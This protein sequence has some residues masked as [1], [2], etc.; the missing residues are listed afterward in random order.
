MG[1]ACP[2]IPGCSRGLWWVRGTTALCLVLILEAGLPVPTLVDG[3]DD[4]AVSPG[5]DSQSLSHTSPW[6]GL[7]IPAQTCFSL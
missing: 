5:E 3:F 6:E 4:Q 7:H 1:N 2:W